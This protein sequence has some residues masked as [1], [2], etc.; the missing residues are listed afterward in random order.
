MNFKANVIKTLKTFLYALLYMCDYS[1]GLYANLTA[2]MVALF[3]LDSF[4][5]LPDL[6]G[7]CKSLNDHLL[8]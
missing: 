6:N 5:E 1:K 4:K 8:Q 3:V 2:I 7:E